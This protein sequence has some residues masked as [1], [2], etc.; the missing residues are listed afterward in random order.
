MIMY[1]CGIEVDIKVLNVKGFIT[2][3]CIRETKIA[4]EISYFVNNEYKQIWLQDYEFSTERKRDLEI[5][6]ISK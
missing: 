4:Y 3:I 6:F 1:P 5:G 2:A